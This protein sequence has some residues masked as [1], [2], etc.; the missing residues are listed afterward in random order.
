MPTAAVAG[1]W[2]YFFDCTFNSAFTISDLQC[3][4]VFTRCNFQGY[5]ITNNLAPA[6]TQYLTFRD[7]TG[8]STLSLGNFILYGMNVK[9]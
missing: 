6:N 4:I 7:C 9:M 2:I 8:L 5:T 3:P 1:G